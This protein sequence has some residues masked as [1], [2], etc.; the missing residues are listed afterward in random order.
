MIEA[1]LIQWYRPRPAPTRRAENAVLVD[2]QA[3]HLQG[4]AEAMT[5]DDTET[6][7]FL[8]ACAERLDRQAEQILN[9]QSATD[10]FDAGVR[11]ERERVYHKRNIVEDA[12]GKVDQSLAE[13]IA[14]ASVPVKRLKSVREIATEPK[15]S[16]L[17]AAGITLNLNFTKKDA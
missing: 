14:K 6:A 12:S 13:L 2:G 11:A 16:A 3:R 4:L 9:L 8:F 15:P 17:K 7:A 5:R 1:P 10:G